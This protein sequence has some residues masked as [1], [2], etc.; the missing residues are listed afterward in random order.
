M[1]VRAVGVVLVGF[2]MAVALTGCMTDPS[3]GGRG[4]TLSE[5]TLEQSERP[6][7]PE[8]PEATT[9]EATSEVQAVIVVAGVDVDGANVSAS[10]YAAGVIE[11]GGACTFR[12]TQGASTLEVTSVSVADRVT[13]SCGV[14]QA[15][16][17]EFTRGT[18]SVQLSYVSANRTSLSEPVEFEVP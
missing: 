8:K 16:A 15:P 12:F 2:G 17:G 14:V 1:V 6:A 18:W 7:V 5:Q 9:S 4:T 10:G 11:D 3:L 13:S